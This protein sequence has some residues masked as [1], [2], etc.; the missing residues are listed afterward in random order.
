MKINRSEILRIAVLA[1]VFA[2]G[3]GASYV[4]LKPKPT[5]PIYNPSD[6][7]PAV[8][9]ESLQGKG[10][11]HRVGD[12]KLQDQNGQWRSQEDLVN[13]IYITDFFFTTCPSICKDMA[14]GMRRLQ[15]EFKDEDRVVL[16]S[17]SVMPKIDTVAQLRDYAD[18]NGAIDDKWIFLTGEEA[19][20]QELARKSYFVVKEDGS[21]FDEHEFIHTDN[22]V[23]VDKKKR[24]RGFYSGV[25]ELEVD[26]L[27]L[28]IRILLAE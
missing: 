21:S 17:H 10:K 12:F 19:Q 25:S 18:R 27:I 14:K 5:L 1:S 26:K 22:F 23:L 3:V 9:D 2:V 16:L 7:N 28:D 20:I 24:L 8:V 15:E 13:K 6:L 11:D 4:I